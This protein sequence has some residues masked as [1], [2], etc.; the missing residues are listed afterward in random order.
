MTSADLIAKIKKQPVG[1]VC[2]LICLLCAGWLYYRNGALEERQKKYDDEAAAAATMISNVSLSKSLPA[3]VAELQAATKE[4]EGRLVRAGQL[5]LNQQYFYRL[6]AGNRGQAARRAP[7][8]RA[9]EHEDH[10]CRRALQ[11][12]RPGFLQERDDL[13]AAPRE[14]PSFLPDLQRQLHQVGGWR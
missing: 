2:G 6:E 4:L 5:A 8:H 13:P 1:F 9:E 14:G 3:E 12:E 7:E 10:L 11:R